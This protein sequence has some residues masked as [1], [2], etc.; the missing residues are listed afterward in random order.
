MFL[1]EDVRYK[2]GMDK[3]ENNTLLSYVNKE[4]EKRQQERER[5]E[6]QERILQE[7]ARLREEQAKAKQAQKEETIK[8][9]EDTKQMVVDTSKKVKE[10]EIAFNLI[11]KNF[12]LVLV[13][14]VLSFIVNCV[15]SFI[16]GVFF[17][18]NL[19][20][21]AGAIVIYLV[22][23]HLKLTPEV[24]ERD[25]QITQILKQN[26]SQVIGDYITYKLPDVIKNNSENIIRTATLLSTIALIVLSSH[27]IFYA[28]A[29]VIT[30]LSIL[31]LIGMKKFA[32][33]DT[34][35]Q[36]LNRAA[37]IG[38]AAKALIMVLSGKFIQVEYMNVA[39]LFVFTYIQF[40][41]KEE[42]PVDINE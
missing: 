25:R 41:F 20:N 27:N 29:V 40:Y 14:S 39:L 32:E 24:N 1:D 9:I 38:V 18:G 10:H 12:K 28:V 34:H 30:L 13:V 7:Q 23:R 35:L 22:M 8:K 11:N 37:L 36:M 17:W 26:M 2:T 16:G 21:A 31:L 42:S 15:L 4:A 19:F 3:D 6:E 33:L 5:E